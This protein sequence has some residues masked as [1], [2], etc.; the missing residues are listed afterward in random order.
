[1]GYLSLNES[2]SFLSNSNED[3]SESKPMFLEA[4]ELALF[5]TLDFLQLSVIF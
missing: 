2:S 3:A 1:M 4:F 5:E